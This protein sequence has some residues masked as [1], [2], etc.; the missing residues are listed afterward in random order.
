MNKILVDRNIVNNID[1]IIIRD[2]VIDIN[3]SGDYEIEYSNLDEIDYI[4]NI[5]N[6]DVV[7]YES[8]FDSEIKVNNIYNVNNGSLEV[9]KFYG[10]KNVNEEVIIN[11]N[12]ENDKVRYNFSNICI[13]EERYI[14]NIN[15][16]NKL[17]ESTISNKSLTLKNSKI[18]F[19]INSNVIKDCNGSKL[20]QNTRI[21]TIDKCDTSV[22]PNMFID[23]DDVEAKHGSVIGT[24]KDEQIFYLMSKGISY[25]DSLKLLI[26][27]YLL[28]NAKVNIDVRKK[29]IDTID[30]YWR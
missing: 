20:D 22:S 30:M 19:V 5:N 3:K 16:K 7:L 9:N 2:N 12:E 29:I 15:H 8:S 1:G 4:I 24:F 25:N 17:T 18:D 28:G 26:K 13:G 27:G 6:C 21:V 11:L 10:N 23:L 14:I